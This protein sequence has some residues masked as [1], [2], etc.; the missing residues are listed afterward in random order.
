MTSLRSLHIILMAAV[1]ITTVV[2]L[3]L[4]F[5]LVFV[6][7]PDRF[8]WAHDGTG[9][10]VCRPVVLETPAI[11]LV[12]VAEFA[13]DAVI[14]INSYDFL[15]WDAEI[16]AALNAYFTPAA[17]RNYLRGFERSRL[18]ANVRESYFTVSAISTRPPMVVAT[19]AVSGRRAWDVQIP[20]QIFYQ[21]GAVTLAGGETQRT[22]HEVFTV[23]VV[24]QAPS[25]ENF[26]GVA[27]DGITTTRVRVVDDLDRIS[28]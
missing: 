23:T 5:V 11:G 7:E 18:L 24:E 19:Y 27:V 10:E 25:R 4:T 28:G 1:A 3:F 14:E 13:R 15:N 17:A 6:T 22:Q 9:E 20:V 12:T 2:L 16:P 8:V 26:R 21:T